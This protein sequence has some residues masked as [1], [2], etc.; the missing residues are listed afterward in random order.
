MKPEN[1]EG[2][3]IED[4][5]SGYLQSLSSINPAK[6]QESSNR[7]RYSL[8]IINSVMHKNLKKRCNWNW[9]F[10]QIGTKHWMKK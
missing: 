5:Q 3:K 7:H 8:W 1:E 9:D 6:K 2:N 4:E 10:Q